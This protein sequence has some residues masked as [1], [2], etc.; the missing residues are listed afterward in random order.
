[1]R[2]IFLVFLGACSYGILSTIVKLAYG[3]G[4]SP[5]EVIGGQMFFGFVLTWIP[6]LFFLRTKPGKKQLLLLVGVGLAVGSTGILYYNALRF[7]PASIAI[8][9]L[10]QF[11]WMGVLAEAILTKRIPDKP[12]LFSLVLLLFGTLLAGG[13]WETGGIAQ[14]HIMGVVLGLLS[15]VSYTLF[16]LFSGKAAV[17]VNLWV[18]SASMSTGSFLLAALVYTPVFLW[19]G[20][21]L[22]GLFP[23][24]FLLALFGIFI[25][26]VC[27]NFG[28]PHTGPGMAAILG[29]A[30]LPMAVFSSY[31]ILHESVSALQVAGVAVILLGI[32]LPEW[33]RQRQRQKQRSSSLR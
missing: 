17:S 12:T 5:A 15:A 18:R 16:L 19:N 28:I 13:V 10:F 7:I 32:V 20:S 14:F 9:L 2:Y 21:L 30:E 24:V 26:T 25:P 22:D 29:A 11:T 27:F 4:Y 3:Q 33:L 1:M 31:I 8:V 6:A 23:Y